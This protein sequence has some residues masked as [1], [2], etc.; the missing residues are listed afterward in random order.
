MIKLIETLLDAGIDWA[1]K[2]TRAENLLGH[3]EQAGIK[4]PRL[5]EDHCQAIM[6]VYMGG[7]SFNQWAEDFEKDEKVVE[8][9]KKRLERKL[10]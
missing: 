5:S 10:K 8:V 6:S 4:P 2:N 9:L 3:L 1:N 7:F